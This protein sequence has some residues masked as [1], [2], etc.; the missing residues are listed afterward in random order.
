M[1]SG[2][3]KPRTERLEEAVKHVGAGGITLKDIQQAQAFAKF[4]KGAVVMLPRTGTAYVLT[5][6]HPTASGVPQATI[7]R[8]HPKVK[9]KAARLQ[10]LSPPPPARGC[11]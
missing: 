10:T 5:E 2:P 6:V 1:S 7:R 11:L 8:A 9:G 4:Q 3:Q